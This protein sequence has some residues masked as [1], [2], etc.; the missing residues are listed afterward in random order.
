MRAPDLPGVAAAIA[1]EDVAALV[2]EL[3]GEVESFSRALIGQ[4][5]S[6]YVALQ[7]ARA[8]A[9]LP[10]DPAGSF[11]EHLV[12][13]AAL[14]PV[15][16][17]AA[18]AYSR[19]FA[20]G[21]VLRRKLTVLAAIL[22]STAPHDAAFATVPGAPVVVVARLAAAGTGF[23]LVLLLGVVVL[24]PLRLITAFESGEP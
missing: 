4:S 24:T 11:D 19:L 5:P 3:E 8:H 9:C 1:G 14:H 6:A 20:R 16:T 23:A 10:L 2:L 12:S 22:E 18:D 15:A 17:R 7:Y 21:T 13:F